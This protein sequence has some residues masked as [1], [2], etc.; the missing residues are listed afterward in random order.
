MFTRLLSHAGFHTAAKPINWDE[1]YSA[2]TYDGVGDE[3]QWAR[4]AALGGIIRRAGATNILDVG[5]GYGGLRDFLPALESYTG[6]DIA[7]VPL[8]GLAR[9]DREQFLCADIENWQPPRTY[10]A[11][12]LSEVLYYLHDIE[13]TLEKLRQRLAYPGVI[14]ASFFQHP[15]RSTPNHVATEKTRRFLQAL[16]PFQEFNIAAAKTWKVMYAR[17]TRSK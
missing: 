5:C 4:Y 2:Q 9:S 14:A 12:V 16:G 17:R 1:T 11:I 15:N 3:F 13:A 10:D 8:N 6:L 7:S